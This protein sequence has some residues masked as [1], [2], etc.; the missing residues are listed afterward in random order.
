MSNGN[1]ALVVVTFFYYIFVA[2]TLESAFYYLNEQ[3]ANNW[4]VALIITGL[5]WLTTWIFKGER[6]KE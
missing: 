6:K 4:I 3:D 1:I 2:T 5:S